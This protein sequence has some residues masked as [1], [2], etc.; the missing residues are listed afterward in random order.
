M[1]LHAKGEVM[2]SEVYRYTFAER[3]SV[4]EL[5]DSLAL[6]V[7]AA[8]SI[9]GE[10]QVRLDAAHF[11]D[12]QG[13]ACVLDAATSVGRDLN[14]LFAGFLTREFGPDAFTVHRVADRTARSPT[15]AAN[16]GT[17]NGGRP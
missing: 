4:D 2:S 3:V 16:S 17:G 11:L 10:A 5:E 7:L 6:A 12:P 9:H 8:E 14:R 13:R 1:I 15:P